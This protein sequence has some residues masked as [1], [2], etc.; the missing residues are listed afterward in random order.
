MKKVNLIIHSI[1]IIAV[2][3]LFVFQ[4]TSVGDQIA[5]KSDDKK[6]TEKTEDIASVKGNLEVA[7][8]N[9]DT[10]L[11]D[12]QMYQDKR[13]EFIEEQTSSQAELQSRSKQL[14]QRV[15]ELREKLN[16]G[17]ITRAKAQMLQKDL[18]QK[19]QQLYQL[20]NQMSSKLAEKEQVI[21]RQVLN[22]VMDYLNEYAA[23]HGYHYILSYSFGGPVLYK[24]QK[25]NITGEVLEGLNERYRKKQADQ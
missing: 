24:N 21:Y 10:L 3:V 14:Q 18:G 6:G 13:E 19:E 17:L 5:G 16:K 20:R 23:E 12:Y 4:F 25:L 9:I 22:S 1:L 11:A 15:Q 8:V 2:A 7:Y